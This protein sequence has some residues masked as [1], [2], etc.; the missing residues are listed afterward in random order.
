MLRNLTKLAATATLALAMVVTGCENLPDLAGPELTPKAPAHSIT[1]VKESDCSA[2]ATLNATVGTE[3]GNLTLCMHKLTIPAGAVSG[4]T[5][6]VMTK[7][8]SEIKIDLTATT[9]GS[10]VLN[11]AGAKGFLKALTLT[12]N[13]SNATN[14]PADLSTLKIYWIKTDGTKVEQP[15]TLNTGTKTVTSYP[16]HF[17]EYAVG[18]PN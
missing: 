10:L 4:P 12:L 3:G 14:L 16:T 1:M 15:T 9:V 11:D 2:G 17:S 7:L 13:Y 5:V 18:W 6:F 8:D